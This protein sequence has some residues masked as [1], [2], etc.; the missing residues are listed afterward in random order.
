MT[1]G[2][3]L[4]SL[5]MASAEGSRCF[6]LSYDP[7]VT[8]LMESVPMPGFEL[9]QLP[10]NAPQISEAWQKIYA[11]DEGL[12]SAQI[13]SIKARALLHGEILQGMGE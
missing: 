2:M 8:R 9:E 5:I 4:H 10:I 3:R 12:Q 13:E 11:D 7:K 6:A 1:I